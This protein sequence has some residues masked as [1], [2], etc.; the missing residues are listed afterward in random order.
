MWRTYA[1]TGLAW[2]LMAAGMP[3]MPTSRAAADSNPA[4]IEAVFRKYCYRCHG[5]DGRSEGGLNVVTDLAKLVDSRRVLPKDPDKSRLFR[6]MTD[7]SMPP[8]DDGEDESGNAPALPRPGAEEVASVRRWILDGAPPART[9]AERKPIGEGEMLKRL[10]DDIKKAGPRDR[11]FLRYF[12]LVHLHNAGYNEDQLETYRRGLSKLVNS[13]SWSRRIRPPTPVDPERTLLRI[14]LRDYLWDEATW[15]AILAR[16]P[17]AMMLQGTAA[18][19]LAEMTGSDLP[20]VRA[21]WFVF[22]ASKPPLYHEA[23]RLPDT[24]EDLERKLDV[25]ALANIRQDRAVRAGFGESG[26]SRNNRLIERHESAHG[27]YWRSYDFA[28]NADRRNLF[29]HP[30]GPGDGPHDFAFDGGEIIFALPNGLHGYM[31][32][33]GRG[34]RIDKGPTEIVRDPKQG[35]SAVVNGLSCMSCHNRGLIDKVDQIRELVTS[36]RAFPKDVAESV[37]ALYP[38]EETMTGLIHADIERFARAVKETGAPVGPT[39]PVYALARQFEDD[40]NLDLAAAESGVTT[41]KFRELMAKDEELGRS[42][43]RLLV[44]GTVK[45]DAFVDAFPEIAHA[46]LL[47]MRDGSAPRHEPT[48][49]A[50]PDTQR[51]AADRHPGDLIVRR[52]T[53]GRWVVL[54]RGRD[55]KGWNTALKG[56]GDAY[57]IPLAEA[58]ADLKYLRLRRLDTNEAL[59][60]PMTRDR[61]TQAVDSHTDARSP[62]RW[63]GSNRPDWGGHHLGIG[64]GPL[65]PGGDQNGRGKLSVQLEGVS[66]F[67]GSGFGHVIHGDTSQQGYGWHGK[68]IAPVDFEIA[69]SAAKPTA[70]EAAALA[71]WGTVPPP[72]GPMGGN[73]GT[74]TRATP[75]ATQPMGGSFGSFTRGTPEPAPKPGTTPT[76]GW[77]EQPPAGNWNGGQAFRDIA[78]AKSYLIGVRVGYNDFMGGNMIGA[79]QPI[80]HGARKSVNGGVYGMAKVEGATVVAKPGYAVG[81]IRTR[82]GLLLN[83]VQL[84]FMRV[85]GDRLDPTDSYESPWLGDSKGG[86]A[87]T[88]GGEGRLVLGLHGRV[89]KELKKLGLVIAE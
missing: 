67:L 76:R 23:L 70:E 6:R 79:I 78:P 38:P 33:D 27:A 36:N 26:V 1:S 86:G 15:D 10:A 37:R 87:A 3:G 28:G 40:V 25:D 11:R 4:E 41:K 12:T 60:I 72:A 42:L 50:G 30:L 35:D 45:R 83:G 53:A 52:D 24:I 29:S 22:A 68:P 66:S 61:L 54:F 44:G 16:N 19:S 32:I 65:I 21:D 80:Y 34:G 71:A 31:L 5:Q 49:T 88:I 55:P 48:N 59:I 62:Y 64:E 9:I 14:D 47:K 84:V 13:L 75:P 57:A 18:E 58:P 77:V 17:Y 20:Y 2:I 89:D 69:V 73:S 8:E 82:T 51:P 43:G 74:F 81:T 56:R 7:G 63:C 85:R 39:E 46:R